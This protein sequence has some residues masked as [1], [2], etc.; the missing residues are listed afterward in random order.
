MPTLP[1][2]MAVLSKIRDESER[3]EVTPSEDP[4]VNSA[5]QLSNSRSRVGSPGSSSSGSSW[6]RTRLTGDW[7][8]EISLDGGGT[9]FG[10]ERDGDQIPDRIAADLYLNDELAAELTLLPVEGGGVHD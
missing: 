4:T 1:R 6:S 5:E 8:D 9:T 10:W 2:N 7:A 3:E